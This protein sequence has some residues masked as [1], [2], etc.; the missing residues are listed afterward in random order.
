MRYL[1]KQISEL[2]IWHY[3][4]GG[5]QE[6]TF[7]FKHDTIWIYSKGEKWIFDLDYI[8]VDRGTGKRNNMKREVDED[9]RTYIQSNL[10]VKFINIMKMRN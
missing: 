5:R 2:N 8:G 10:Q 9:G 3:Q 7:S 1:C 4:S 6:N